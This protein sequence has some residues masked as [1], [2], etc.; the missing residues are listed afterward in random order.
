[1]DPPYQKNLADRALAMVEESD[2]LT[3]DAMILIEEHHAAVLPERVGLLALTD[4]RRYG[5]TALWFYRRFQQQ[6]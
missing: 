3:P 5:E 6:V 2:L 1:M 4:R